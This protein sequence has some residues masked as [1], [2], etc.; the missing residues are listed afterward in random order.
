VKDFQ[1]GRIE[2]KTV[3]DLRKLIEMDLELQKDTLLANRRRARAS[4]TGAY[5]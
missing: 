5:E 1:D 3:D 4:K 2:I